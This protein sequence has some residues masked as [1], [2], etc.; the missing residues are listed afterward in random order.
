MLFYQV[1]LHGGADPLYGQPNALE[2]IRMFNQENLWK[3]RFENAPGFGQANSS[4]I[5]QPQPE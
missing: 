3:N 2:C 4:Q 5:I 1:L